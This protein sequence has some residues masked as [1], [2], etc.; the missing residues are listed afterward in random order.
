[1]A[2]NY[3]FVTP[4]SYQMLPRKDATVAHMAHSYSF[5]TVILLEDAM[6]IIRQRTLSA[7]F[8]PVVTKAIHVKHRS[9]SG[10]QHLE[11]GLPGVSKLVGKSKVPRHVS[12]R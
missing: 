2:H 7:W 10:E 8:D 9:S 5:H 4:I 11:G 3:S 12:D 6:V 1:M